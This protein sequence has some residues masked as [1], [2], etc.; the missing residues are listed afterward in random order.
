MKNTK[1]I[2]R[3]SYNQIAVITSL[4]AVLCVLLSGC[5]GLLPQ[6]YD[7]EIVVDDSHSTRGNQKVAQ[8][9]RGVAK[10][11]LTHLRV[12]AKNT[13]TIRYGG[14]VKELACDGKGT[15]LQKMRDQLNALA[16]E[17]ANKKPMNSDD[18]KWPKLGHR[19]NPALHFPVL[20]DPQ[21]K[22]LEMGSP[23]VETVL[24]PV[25]SWIKDRPA[26]RNLM[27]IVISDLVADPTVYRDGC[28]TKYDDP[29]A[30]RWKLKKAENVHLRFYMVGED[31]K[32]LL[33][34]SWTDAPADTRFFEPGHEVDKDDLEPPAGSAG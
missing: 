24:N 27:A 15:S 1:Q 17:I 6:R 14:S 34:A 19:H 3:R 30:F 7:T 32:N 8:A 23:I 31:V 13:V 2:S 28:I 29:A 22:G 20:R 21:S 5:N 33:R 16:D 26:S 18:I 4:L 11:Y 9:L 10:V 25:V 12:G